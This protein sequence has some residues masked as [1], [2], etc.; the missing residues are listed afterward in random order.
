MSARSVLVALVCA[1]IYLVHAL[2]TNRV[3]DDCYITFR[4]VRNWVE[5]NGPV[6]NP[7]ERVEGYTN[8]L[9][10][11]LLAGAKWA[12][13][14][15]DLLLAAQTLG[16]ACGV[17]LLLQVARFGRGGLFAPLLLALSGPFVVWSTGGLE[18]TLFA[19]LVFGAALAE[20]RSDA[21]GRPRAAA[22]L[23]LALATMTRPDGIV[24]VGALLIHRAL[25]LAREGDGVKRA[26]A[27]AAVHGLL[28]F[29][30]VY[31]PYWAWRS[32]YYGW[33]V[34]NTF[35]AKV[36]SGLA[37]WRRG[38]DYVVHFAVQGGVVVA[39]LPLLPIF[40][41]LREP[42]VRLF[43]LF[44]AAGLFY[45]VSVGGESLGLYRFIV[46]LLPFVALLAQEGLRAIG[47]R[48]R[49]LAAALAA[50]SLVFAAKPTIAPRL[51]P[52]RFGMT[53]P[54][55]GLTFPGDGRVHDYRWFDNYFVDRLAV[56]ARWIDG[57][58]PQDALV[59]STPAG[60]IGFHMRQPLLDMLGLNDATI[61]HAPVANM[62]AGRAGHEK[63]DG[64]YVLSRRP[65]FILLDNVAVFDHPLTDDEVEQR[66]RLRSEHEIWADPAFH[67]DYE[68]RTVRMGDVELAAVPAADR[69]LFQWFTFWERRA[70]D[71][72]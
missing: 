13:P 57:H 15:L 62:G 42:W 71:R 72:R 25:G 28:V 20:L 51:S 41:R 39:L 47:S 3:V 32:W 55:S 49:A 44:L 31:G 33:P 69:A 66:L 21:S 52:Q 8:F 59:A 54:Q 40:R 26:G 58:A 50:V 30:L 7:G 48:S 37:Q 56:A 67:R 36:G 14:R 29:A 61:A 65:R 64:R 53:E 10:T 2:F 46:P 63:G 19:L 9:W 27:R 4:Y 5:G 43:A 6:F 35:Y 34:P 17:V 22:P 45:V 23:L 68:K 38:A 1:T 11:A 16:L 12:W 60:S 70:D 18:T 24:F